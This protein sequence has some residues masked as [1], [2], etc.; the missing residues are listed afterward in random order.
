[1]KQY[2]NKNKLK[3]LVEK[4]H[5]Y[6]AVA[7]TINVNEKTIARWAHKFN[8]PSIGS[9]G[10]RKYNLDENFFKKIDTN[11]K[12]YWLGFL[13]A[14]GCVYKNDDKKSYRLQ[15][16]L[17]YSDIEALEKFNNA[18]KSNYPIRKVSVLNKKTEKTYTVAQLK[19]NCTV[20]CHDLIALGVKPRKSL[21][22]KIPYI[23][24]M[25][26]SHFIRGYFD[27]DGCITKDARGRWTASIVGGS[28]VLDMLKSYLSSYNIHSAIYDIKHS[29]AKSLEISNKFHIQK[30]GQLL[31]KDA[32][33]FY[34][35]KFLKFQALDKF[36][37]RQSDMAG[38]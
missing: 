19:I 25:L 38:Q 35:R 10:A 18:I 33:T 30:F 29:K 22:C 8:I 24:P 14:D 17:A 9:Q 37:S 32:T 36:L 3:E 27:G 13:M 11:T 12:A 5:T 20:M 26:F 34:K 1:M 31:Y 28:P 15:I 23:E 21:V 4:Y 16:N 6:T 2:E 7:K